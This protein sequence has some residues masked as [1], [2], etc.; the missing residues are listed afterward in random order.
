[1]KIA[2]KEAK[3]ALLHNDIPVGSLIVLD[4]VII[5]KAHNMV[6]KKNS[7]IAHA[8]MLA[9]EKARKKLGEKYL[10]NAILY[11]TLEPCSLCSGAIIL[12]RIKTIVF[13]A[14]DLKAGACGSVL[15]IAHNKLLNHRCDI[16]SGIMRED[17]SNLLK[18]FFEEL[19]KK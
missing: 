11:S 10:P 5:A 6:E 2:L 15:N 18:S 19:R 8:E 9:L 1:M 17:C 13:G 3:K 7:S 16:I 14:F 12:S 4:G